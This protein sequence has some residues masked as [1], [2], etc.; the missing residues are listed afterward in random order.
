[1][2]IMMLCSTTV[3]PLICLSLVDQALSL[4]YSL[5][6]DTLDRH[7]S[8]PCGGWALCSNFNLLA[9]PSFSVC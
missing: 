2:T 4:C 8:A 3:L 6:L 9:L 7:T 5:S 1:M